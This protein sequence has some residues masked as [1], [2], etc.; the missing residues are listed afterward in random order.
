MKIRSTVIL[1]GLFVAAIVVFA[2]FQKMGIKTGDESKHAE[3]FVFPSLNPYGVKQETPN[4]QRNP[5]EPPPK[6]QGPQQPKPEDFTSLVI[7][8]NHGEGKKPEKLVFQRV[9]SGKSHKWMLVEPV[10]VRTDDTAV[11]TLI[12]SLISLEKQKARDIGR[13]MAALGLEKPDTTVTLTRDDKQ[14]VLSLGTTGPG[15]KDPVY[16]A[17]SSDWSG[18]PFLMPK[19][20]IEKVFDDLSQFRNKTLISSS[21]GI[22]GLKLAGTARSAMELNKE[23]EWT[24]K[25][26]TIGAADT[27]VTDEYSRQLSAI[28]V[29]RNEDYLVDGADAAK[30][31]Q[32]GLSDDKPAYALTLT[33]SPI[34]QKDKPLVEVL[35]VGNADDSAIKNAAQVRGAALVVESLASPTGSLAAYVVREKQKVEPAYY[36]ARLAGDQTVV[37]IAAR[38]L[39]LLQKKADELRSKLLAKI[40]NSKV[41]AVQY[42]SQ[43][44]ALRIYRP[45]LQAAASW[46]LYAENRGKVKCQPQTIQSMLDAMTRI[47]VRDAKAFLDDDAKIKAWFD[48]T[49]IDLGLDKPAATIQVWQDGILRDT[50]GKPEGTAEPKMREDLKTK[51]TLKLSIGRKDD[52][53]KVTYVRR[54]QPGLKPVILAVPDPFISGNA[55]LGAT[56]T[57]A[58]PPDGRQSFSISGMAG[59]GYLQFRDRTLPGYRPDQISTL[60]VKRQGLNYLLEH[61]TTTGERGTIEDSWK[62]KQ[63]VEGASNPSVADYIVTN[64]IGTNTEKLITDRASDKELDE[65]YGLVKSPLLQVVV[66]TRADTKPSDPNAKDIAKPHPGGTFTYTIGKKLPDNSKY[67]NHYAARVEVKLAD[68][69]TPDSN[70]FVL[71]APASFLQSLDI[72][73]RDC[74]VIP[75]DKGKPASLQLTWHGEDKDKKPVVTS[76]KLSLGEK[77]WEV[78]A[79]TENGVDAKAKLAKLDQVKVNSLLRYGPQPAPGGASL[80]PLVVDRFVQHAGAIDPKFRLDPANKALPPKLVMEVKYADGKTR[81]V[82]LGDLLKPSET[83][84]PAW[85]GST[86]FYAATPALPGAVMLVNELNWRALASG[87]EYFAEAATKEKQ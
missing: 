35:L 46:D 72:E 85:A 80:N 18:K 75:E 2:L 25:E 45:D 87:V 22:V 71:A 84:M 79:L 3:R 81:T 73:L 7:E 83:T 68:G 64:L 41:D 74:V 13:D 44:E 38:H 61:V 69:T 39:P 42:A 82:I 54:E 6:P 67:P 37:R 86:F 57:G 33:Q 43:G 59:M 21:F 20:K 47:E 1:F 53:R 16:F 24:F 55:P 70:Q 66:K 15:A 34:D 30:L 40:D 17:S 36:Y 12:R 31:A 77:Q 52:Q 48:G 9:A 32:F 23:Q 76:L 65:T 51:P 28:K 78:N 26:P 14:Y 8:R 58:V 62:L 49:I 4:Q 11:N 63:P 56:Q 19:S 27:A 29:E 5:G 10:K 60:E 50:N